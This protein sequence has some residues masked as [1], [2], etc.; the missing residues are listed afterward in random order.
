M[1]QSGGSRTWSR[2]T[3]RSCDGLGWAEI[4]VDYWWK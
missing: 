3:I 2:S 1:A 4:F